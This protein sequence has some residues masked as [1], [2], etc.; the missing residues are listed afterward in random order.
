MRLKNCQWMMRRE[1]VGEPFKEK[2][3]ISPISVMKF[4]IQ[5]LFLFL[6]LEAFSSFPQGLMTTAKKIY[7]I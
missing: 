2:E 7:R 4:N 6:G 1:W 3:K 5:I